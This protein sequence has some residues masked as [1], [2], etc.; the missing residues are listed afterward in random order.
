MAPHRLPAFMAFLM[1]LVQSYIACISI[2]MRRTGEPTKRTKTYHKTICLAFGSTVCCPFGISDI[3]EDLL[4]NNISVMVEKLTI[5]VYHRPRSWSRLTRARSHG[6]PCFPST[7]FLPVFP[8]GEYRKHGLASP[9]L[10]CP[11]LRQ[12][13][14]RQ[15]VQP[16]PQSSRSR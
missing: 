8:G 10:L 2:Y 11:A 1:D 6:D 7:M 12:H 14:I 15:E 5:L 9:G 4:T 13:R 16:H 3:A